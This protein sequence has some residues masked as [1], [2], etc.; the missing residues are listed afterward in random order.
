MEQGNNAI[1]FKR[2]REQ[3]SKNER[4]RG[5]KAIFGNKEHRKLRFWFRR[6]EEENK[7]IYFRGTGQ[8]VPPLEG[9][10]IYLWC[11]ASVGGL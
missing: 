9:P 4:N 1:C 5:I 10:Q 11:S 8:Q 3:M 7:E 2:T 6:R